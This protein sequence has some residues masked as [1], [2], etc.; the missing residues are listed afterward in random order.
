[1]ARHLLDAVDVRNAKPKAKPYRLRDGDGLFLYMPPSGVA[2]WQYRYKLE[3]KSQTLTIGKLAG[4]SLAEARKRAEKARGEAADGKNLTTAKR[5]ARAKVA[6]DEGNTFRAM[7]DSWMRKRRDPSWSATHRDQ[8]QASIDNHLD[9]LYPLP[10]TEITAALVTPVL[11]GVERRAPLMF[12][13]VRARLHRILDHAVTRGALERNPLPK[14]EPE[15]RR[16]RRNFPAVTDLAGVGKILRAARAADPSKGIQRAHVLLAFTGQRVSEVVGAT[17]SEFD[18]EAGTWTI[19]RERM[20]RKDEARGPHQVPIPPVLLAQLK[21]WQTAD[22]AGAKLVC[23]APRNAERSVTPEGVEKFYRDALGLQGKHSPHSW[24]SAFS[25]IARDAGKDGDV[26]E[27]Q[28]D[29]VVG[30]K[31]ASAYDR[32]TRFELRR[33]LMRWYEGQLIAARDGADIVQLK[34]RA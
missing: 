26:V 28:L 31:V 14:P 9:A 10:V 22:G 29:H 30:N 24:R 13:K 5:L 18:L 33:K 34:G 19:P 1:M 12:E 8:V 7:A 2:A 15:R 17:W 27:A 11:A 32:A 16:N 3:S 6:R 4:M 21:E 25:T 23:A 20:K